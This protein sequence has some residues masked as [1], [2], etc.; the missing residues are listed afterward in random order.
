M[1]LR[2]LIFS[3][4]VMSASAQLE[5][6]TFKPY[7]HFGYEADSPQSH[8]RGA[9][10]YVNV[11]NT[12]YPDSVG[13]FYQSGLFHTWYRPVEIYGKDDYSRDKYGYHCMEGGAGYKPYLHFRSQ[14]T[15]QKFTTGAVA[16]GFGSFSNGPGQGVP[17]FERAKNS[18]S[19]GWDKNL[20]RYGA[21]QLSNRLIYPLDGV[22]FKEGSNNQMLGYGYYAL[23]LTEPKSSTAGT[24]APSG[25]HC[26]TLFF[27]TKN[28]SGPVCFFTPYHWA[29]YSIENPHLHGQCLD[30]SFLKVNSVYQRETNVIPAKQWTAANGDVYYR[31]SP[32]TL[33]VDKDG[34]TR[35]GSM[36][37]TFDSTKWDQLEAWFSGGQP[38]PAGFGAIGK[39]IHLRK[40]K[41][42]FFNFRMNKT[43]RVDTKDFITQVKDSD[44][45]ASAYRWNGTLATQAYRPDLVKLPEY[46]CLKNGSKTIVA[47]P[48]RDVPRESK[49]T[50]VDF[51][52]DARED[53]EFD[54][55]TND[56][57]TTPLNP[58]YTYSDKVVD[59]W[60]TP[61][62]V[63]GPFVTRLSDGSQVVYYWYKFNEQPAILNS[64]MDD[65]ERELIQK[66]VELIHRHWSKDDQYFPD[67]AQELIALDDGLIVTP[68]KGLEAGYVPICVHQQLA[69][70]KLPDFKTVRR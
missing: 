59:V 62:P 51:P 18:P 66:R 41:T 12:V 40:N 50:K 57:I 44:P 21:A 68:P 3:M 14:K 37:M 65:A 13:S 10:H 24:D 9:F 5:K 46:Y 29:K 17:S 38:A 28:F 58:E 70:E 27:N 26:W 2:Y 67:P 7:M 69:G 36:P 53:F 30:S 52:A 43:I 32:Y 64:H 45:S 61:G 34:I 16:G 31:I 39:E 23:P 4:L 25:N 56:P 15:P 19:L 49:L 20:G 22:G 8:N 33:P 6:A 35:L 63:A 55:F 54:G 47:I 11:H 60:K 42:A 48:E 1:K